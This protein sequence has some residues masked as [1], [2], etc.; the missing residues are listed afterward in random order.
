MVG[1]FAFVLKMVRP[2]CSLLRYHWHVGSD[3]PSSPAIS[4]TASPDL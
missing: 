3:A 2:K 1:M 4:A